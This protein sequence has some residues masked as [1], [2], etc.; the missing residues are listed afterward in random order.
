M[1]L[2]STKKKA[3]EKKIIVSKLEKKEEEKSLE[4]PKVKKTIIKPEPSLE[5]ILKENNKKEEDE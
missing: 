4:L 3:P 5:I 2:H 1:F